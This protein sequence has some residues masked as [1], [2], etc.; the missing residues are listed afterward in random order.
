MKKIARNAAKILRK[1][2]RG[3]GTN[4]WDVLKIFPLVAGG[5]FLLALFTKWIGFA[6]AFAVVT[7]PALALGAVI[8]FSH[9]EE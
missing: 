6:A 4:L 5:F 1:R 2:D 8:C 7:I 3:T 9:E